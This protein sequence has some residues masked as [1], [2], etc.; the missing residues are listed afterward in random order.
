MPK[1]FI[2]HITYKDKYL[3]YRTKDPVLSGH[4]T[5]HEY[6]EVLRKAAGVAF[7]DMVLVTTYNEES[8]Q[9]MILN[10]EQDIMQSELRH[11]Q[12]AFPIP[13]NVV[14]LADDDVRPIHAKRMQELRHER[15]WS[16]DEVAKKLG[17]AQTT[18]AG[19]E[20]GRSEPD[21]KTLVRIAKLFHTSTDYI[22]GMV[23]K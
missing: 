19:Y 16:Q 7:E 22:L 13:K 12:K 2:V 18:Y 10:P 3:R 21:F 17:V 11:L 4:Y 9:K 6:I 23:H 20:I 8:F 5:L 1:T 14:Q 15:G